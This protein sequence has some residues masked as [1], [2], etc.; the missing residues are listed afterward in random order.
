MRNLDIAIREVGEANGFT[1]MLATPSEENL[2][3]DMAESKIL[4]LDIQQNGSFGMDG[5][6]FRMGA[7]LRI[8]FMDDQE[9][10]EEGELANARKNEMLT[11]AY[12]TVRQLSERILREGEY[13]IT[14]SPTWQVVYN[15]NDRNKIDI[16]VELDVL[17]TVIRY[18]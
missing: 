8:H 7:H 6:G 11:E 16:M 2:R 3:A 5:E 12:S 15:T 18:C 9:W 17:E 13:E 4:W 10:D 1:F 14:S